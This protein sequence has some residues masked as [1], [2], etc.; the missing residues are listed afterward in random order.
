MAPGEGIDMR[1]NRVTDIPRIIEDHS[2]PEPNSGCWLWLGGCNRQGYGKVKILGKTTFA[3]RASFL[4]FVSEIPAGLMVLHRCDNPPCV[5]PRHL[6]L[7][8]CAD[9]H[10]DRGAKNRQARGDRQGLRLHPERAPKGE[11]NGSAKLDDQSVREI[12]RRILS[13]EARGALA[14]SFGVSRSAIDFI[15]RRRTWQHV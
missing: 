13:G 6:F 15:H 12:R 7:G 10:A 1:A 2:I 8:T 14:E 4:S 9:N 5:N 11:R 3:H